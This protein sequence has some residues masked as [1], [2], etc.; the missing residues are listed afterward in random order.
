MDKLNYDE[1]KW[2]KKNGICIKKRRTKH[3]YINLRTGEPKNKY[4][5]PKSSYGGSYGGICILKY[6]ANS[7]YQKFSPFRTYFNLCDC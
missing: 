6:N 7:R 3:H 2:C 5:G 4:K 1:A